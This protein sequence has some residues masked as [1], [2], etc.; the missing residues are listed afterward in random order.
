[1]GSGHDDVLKQDECQWLTLEPC[2]NTLIYVDQTKASTFQAASP[3]PGGFVRVLCTG[4]LHIGRRSSHA[5][6]D[7]DGGYSCA[8]IWQDIVDV[9]LARQVDLVVISGDIIDSANRY[10]EALGAFERGVTRLADAG[11]QTV[12]VGGNHDWDSLPR[13]AESLAERNF[14]LIGQQGRWERIPIAVDGETR[15][16]IEGWSFPESRMQ[17]SPLAGYDLPPVTDGLPVLGLLHADLDQFDSPYAPVSTA[18]LQR[19][20]VSLWLLGHVHLPRLRDTGS[21][22]VLYP[23][24]PLAMDHGEGGAHGV[25][26]IDLQPGMPPHCVLVAVSP[27][28]YLT[29]PVDVS[30]IASDLDFQTLVAEAARDAVRAQ[31]G[32]SDG[33]CVRFVSLRISLTGRSQDYGALERR[34]AVFL[35]ELEGNV[36]RVAYAVDAISNLARPA[37]DLQRLATGADP[38]AVVAT[39]ILHLESDATR[40]GPLQLLMERATRA[41]Q[42]TAR[43]SHYDAVAG[44]DPLAAEAINDMLRQEAYRLLETLVGQKEALR[45]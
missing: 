41:G 15:L 42:D 3:L 7:E 6:P 39:L 33:E 30:A 19:A 31:A 1:M 29:I 28:R 17:T 38:P 2:V 43:R 35:P 44:D 26:L 36:G 5:P 8:D 40:D 22:P 11:I 14:Q 23:G 45:P 10:L 12:A 16:W 13:L 18:E 20:P 32:G 37:L 25:W 9:A 21:I 27:I 34:R 4:D 24:S